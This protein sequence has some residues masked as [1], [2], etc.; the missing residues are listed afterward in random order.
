[1]YYFQAA[2]PEY[3]KILFVLRDLRR[4]TGESLAAYYVRT[5]GHLIP[6]GAEV[7]E[8]DDTTQVAKRVDA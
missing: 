4:G 1:M 3:Q 6:F 8:Y 7:W 2:P 5:Y